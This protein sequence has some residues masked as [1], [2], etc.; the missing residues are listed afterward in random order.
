[1]SQAKGKPA[2]RRDRA[3]E[4]PEPTPPEPVAFGVDADRPEHMNRAFAVWLVV[5][6]IREDPIDSAVGAGL[7]LVGLPL[8]FYF[9]RSAV[10][11]QLSA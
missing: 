11:R 2:A 4:Q 8:Y 6:T 1:M 7:I 5:N 9:K 3:P 10:S